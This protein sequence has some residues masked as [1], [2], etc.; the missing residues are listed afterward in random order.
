MRIAQFTESYKPV[1][2]GVAVAMDLLLEEFRQRHEIAVF[3][4]RFSG[5]PD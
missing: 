5:Y 4:P 3:S 2:N 1:I